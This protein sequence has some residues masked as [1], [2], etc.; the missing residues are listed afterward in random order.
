MGKAG[1]PAL[2][3]MDATIISGPMTAVAEADPIVTRLRHVLCVRNNPGS[4]SCHCLC[5]PLPPYNKANSLCDLH[6]PH[7][8]ENFYCIYHSRYLRIAD[9]HANCHSFR[10]RDVSPVQPEHRSKRL[11]KH[12]VP[13]SCTSR[14]PSTCSLPP[15]CS[16]LSPFL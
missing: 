11:T 12:P 13:A 5:L 15:T 6:Q 1:K 9:C 3:R 2:I 16:A 14:P 10:A 4:G 8:R 7:N